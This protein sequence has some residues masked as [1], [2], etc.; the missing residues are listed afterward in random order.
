MAILT[1][2]KAR[3]ITLES[4]VIA[5]G[6]VTGLTL[7]PSNTKGSGKWVLRY[8]SPVTQKRRNA[9]LGSY[10]EVSISR[11]AKAALEMR[12]QIEQGIDPLTEKAKITKIQKTPSFEDASRAL[13]AEL[14]PSWKNEK[15]GQQWINTLEQYVFPQIGEMLLDQIQPRHIADTLRPI[16]LEI[17]ETAGRVKQRIHAVMAW[18]WAHEYCPSNPVDVVQHLLPP[19]PNKSIRTTHQPAMHWEEIPNFIREHLREFEQ[20]DVTRP[21]LEFLILTA[22]RS[23]EVRGMT[24]SEVDFVKKIWTVPA[25]RMK[26]KILHRVPLSERG[27]EILKSQ[28]GLHKEL[29]FPSPRKQV[30]LSDMVLTSF[31]RRTKAKSDTPGRLATAHGFRSSFRDWCSVKGYARDL[32]ERS[33]A[34]TIQNRVEAAYHRTDLLDQRRVLMD[35]WEAFCCSI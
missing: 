1:D 3:S 6:G 8:V 5:H 35:A 13:H 15:H 2:A 16:W 27:L 23:G 24:W 33:L 30:E 19:Q 20:Y 9:G 22:A 10:P 29:V 21:M 17:P 34:H 4:G 26:A 28:V 18:G 14:L 25:E 31:L 7:H 11:A 12:S 32:A